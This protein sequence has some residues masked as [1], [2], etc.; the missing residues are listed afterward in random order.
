[1]SDIG[2]PTDYTPELAAKICEAIAGSSK[3][4]E[5]LCKAHK[6]WPD[7]STIMRWVNRHPEFRDQY[8]RAKA[9][10]IEAI[11]DEIIDIADTPPKDHYDT[12]EDI[13]RAKLRIDTRKWLASKLAPKIY[14]DQKAQHDVDINEKSQEEILRELA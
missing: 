3:G 1:M 2:R 9:S 13:S 5:R 10:Q 11:V 7:K 4:I 6:E 14:G 12:H 8:A